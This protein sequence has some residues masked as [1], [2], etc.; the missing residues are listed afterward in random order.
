MRHLEQVTAIAVRVIL[1]IV[2]I[3]QVAIAV[4]MA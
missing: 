2:M 3:Y 4:Y 1:S